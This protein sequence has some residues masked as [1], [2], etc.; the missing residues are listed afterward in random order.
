[1]RERCPAALA[2]HGAQR[3]HPDADEKIARTV[4][5]GAGFEEPL[6]DRDA[7][8]IVMGVKPRS[9]AC[10]GQWPSVVGCDRPRWRDALSQ[11][12]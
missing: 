9:D 2:A 1:V 5:T 11:R 8:R 12:S 3:R 6:K 4:F 10:R 7:C